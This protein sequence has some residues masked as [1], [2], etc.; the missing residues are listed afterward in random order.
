MAILSPTR[1]MCFS[2]CT[3]SVR[4]LSLSFRSMT[5]R[6]GTWRMRTS[7]TRRRMKIWATSTRWSGGTWAHFCWST[8][9]WSTWW[10]RTA[11]RATCSSSRRARRYL[12]RCMSSKRTSRTWWSWGSRKH[13][14][15]IVSLWDQGLITGSRNKLF[16]ST[17]IT[18]PICSSN[19]SRI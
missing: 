9:R 14:G 18:C 19:A 4:S 15:W 13:I 10:T 17:K 11:T 3:S 1:S 16:F 8:T 2:Q 5:R 6:S 12:T 7:Q